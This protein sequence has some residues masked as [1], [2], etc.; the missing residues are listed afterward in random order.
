VAGKDYVAIARSRI[1]TPTKA[2]RMPRLFIYARNKKGKTRFCATAP[3]VLILDPEDGTKHEKRANP[4]VWPVD[5]WQDVHDAIGFLRSRHNRS[6]ITGKPYQWCA[7]DG[8]TKIYGKA[9]NFVRS[10]EGMADLMK[11]PSAQI[12][13]R[14]FGN[15]NKLIEEAVTQAHALRD[16]GLIFTAQERIVEVTMMEDFGDDEDVAPTAWAYVTDMPKGARRPFYEV[17]DVIGRMYV[18]RGEFTRVKRFRKGDRIVER[19]VPTS[20]QR[21]LWIGPHEMYDT[22]YRSEHE[23]PDFIKNPTVDSLVT[24]IR[25]GKVDE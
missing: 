21:R 25:T 22:G 20:T 19:E 16:I 1:T 13:R 3:D 12:D 23:L 24:A 17:C 15:A 11:K 18:V 2:E 7:W 6:P 8:C 5:S 9:L 14:L 10:A 4:N